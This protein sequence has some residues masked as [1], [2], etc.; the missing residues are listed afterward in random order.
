MIPVRV[1]FVVS[2][3]DTTLLC[4]HHQHQPGLEVRRKSNGRMKCSD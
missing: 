3:L 1:S 4:G 2:G